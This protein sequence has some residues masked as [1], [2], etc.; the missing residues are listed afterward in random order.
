MRYFIGY[1]GTRNQN[2]DNIVKRIEDLFNQMG[3]ISYCIVLTFS[4]EVHN[5]EVTPE[6]FYDQAASL[7]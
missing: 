3:G 1:V 5:S 7:N 4:E 2:L 6:E